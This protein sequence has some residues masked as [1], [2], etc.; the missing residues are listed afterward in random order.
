MKRLLPCALAA[1]A[2]ASLA[3][4]AQTSTPAP[5]STPASQQPASAQSGAAAPQAP[6]AAQQCVACHGAQGEGNPGGGIPRIAGQSQR[7]LVRQLESYANGTRFNAVMQP[8]AKGFSREQMA[9][10][11]AYFSQLDAPRAANSAANTQGPV[12]APSGATGQ[13]GANA[14]PGANPQAGS[15][16]QTSGNA[17]A[18]PDRGSV[19][20]ARGDN[21][22]RIQACRNCH[23]PGGVGEP[24]LYPYIAGLDARYITATLNDWKSGARKND[25]G[26]QM[27]TVARAMNDQDIA[28]VAQYFAGLAPP[29]PAPSNLVQAVQRQPQTGSTPRTAQ[30]QTGGAVSGGQ[31]AGP[32]HPVG[33]EQGSPTTGGSQGPGGTAASG[34]KSAR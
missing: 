27:A 19:L 17:P 34:S 18:S 30:P 5:T 13:A 23:G 3:V 21:A 16:A 9:E 20:E 12:N 10:A 32:Q 2:L 6:P 24:P 28:A 26:Q 33:T 14:P 7:Y 8:I 11:A 4:L 25:P 1:S 15:S 29:K 22:R 31:P